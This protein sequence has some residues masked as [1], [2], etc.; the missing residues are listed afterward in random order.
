M[1]GLFLR[2]ATSAS[3][4]DP[5]IQKL[6]L[7]LKRI[8][9]VG[10]DK[11]ATGEQIDS[12]WK[13][14]ERTAVSLAS[15]AVPVMMDWDLRKRNPF[16][17]ESIGLVPGAIAYCVGRL[18]KSANPREKGLCMM[19]LTMMCKEKGISAPTRRRIAHAAVRLLD[20]KDRAATVWICAGLPTFGAEALP[21][22]I[23]R[24]PHLNA[25]GRTRAANVLAY[26][27]SPRA[28]RE[29][30]ILTHD[31]SAVVR[32]RARWALR[33]QRQN[34]FDDVIRISTHGSRSS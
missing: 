24:I 12:A 21:E 9:T 13:E 34:P 25:L 8:D 7:L 15:K 31:R 20:T 18:E 28:V 22:I 33:N 26:L 23:Q 11:N 32:S 1:F 6:R 29:L 30:S 16:L 2:C 3:A 17:E 4:E 19:T 5:Q 10:L 14:L 27:G